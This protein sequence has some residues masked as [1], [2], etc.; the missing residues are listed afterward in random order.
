MKWLSELIVMVHV[1]VC[2]AF[3]SRFSTNLWKISSCKVKQM[4]GF[5]LLFDIIISVWVWDFLFNVTEY[6][7]WM[8][9][10]PQISIELFYGISEKKWCVKLTIPKKHRPW[11]CNES[12]P[13]SLHPNMPTPYSIILA[14][15]TPFPNN[16]K[17]ETMSNGLSSLALQVPT[18]QIY[19]RLW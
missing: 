19:M 10:V 17:M 1:K 12:F 16:L 15:M 4:L 11:P 6:W 7:H 18:L 3:L 14:C 9:A 13:H 8:P 5:S 2:S